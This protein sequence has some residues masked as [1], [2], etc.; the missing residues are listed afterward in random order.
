MKKINSFAFWQ[1][2]ITL[3]LYIYTIYTQMQVTAIYDQF[4]SL[5]TTPPT[6]FGEFGLART[7]YLASLVGNPQDDY[8]VIHIAGTSGK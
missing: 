4:L 2:F 8:P 3:L 1:Y 6:K 5:I 7:K